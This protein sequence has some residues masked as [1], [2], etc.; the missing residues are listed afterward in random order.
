MSVHRFDGFLKIDSDHMD[1][2]KYSAADRKMTVRFSNGY[3]YAVHGV[4]VDAYKDFL[5]APSHGEHYHKFLK[6]Q[7]YVERIR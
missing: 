3:Q 7:Y 1:G 6:S 4:S 5:A 2:V